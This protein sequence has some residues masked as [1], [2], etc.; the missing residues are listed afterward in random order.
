VPLAPELA[1]YLSL[2]IAEGA[3]AAGGEV[4][5][6]FV[7]IG[8]EGTVALVRPKRENPTG[9]AES[10]IRAILARLLDASGALTPAL[11]AASRK[12]QSTGLASLIE[13]LEAAL[14]P[15]NRAAGRRALA[16]LAREVK[17]VT[18]GVGRNAPARGSSPSYAAVRDAGPDSRAPSR[19]SFSDDPPVTAK[20]DV[21]H[22]VLAGSVP[23]ELGAPDAE[24]A[25]PSSGDASELPTIELRKEQLQAALPKPMRA[26]LPASA[27]RIDPPSE[28][29]RAGPDE[30]DHL[31]ESFGVSSNDEQAAA[32]ELKALVGLDPTPP[33]PGPGHEDE[34]DI[35]GRLI[36]ETP[37]P[38]PP[39]DRPSGTA[40][41][42]DSADVES[43][44]AMSEPGPPVVR[45]LPRAPVALPSPPTAV[46]AQAPERTSTSAPTSPSLRKIAIAAGEF[47]PPRAPRTDR[48]LALIALFILF[49]GAIAIWMLKPGFFT[50]RTPDRIEEERKQAEV[51]RAQAAAAQ[52]AARCKATLI[53]T[54]VPN[55]AEVLLRVGQAPADVE[56]MPV[57]ARLEFVA[58][59]EGFAPKRT[60]VP[61]GAK[62]DTGPDGKP[63][64]EVA[65]Q[66]DKSRAR[67]GGV[68][69]WPAGEPGS[70]V[71][72][73]GS[74]GTV[75]LVSTPR[76][77]ELWL[78]AGIGPEAR[79]DQLRCGTDVD[80]LVAGP[81]TLRK[82]IHVA[83]KDMTGGE[84]PLTVSASGK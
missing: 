15:V 4:D 11:G 2:E 78:L 13:E 38:V 46:M 58:T 65:V 52:Q 12:K 35:D 1:G 60:V 73:K 37:A 8:D 68:D 53:V 39:P 44:L 69:H 80:V 9:D 27:S 71:G 67:P 57:G 21:P 20:R 14:I 70:E 48:V 6:R 41:P 63:R 51:D 64:F 32:R 54:D 40:A 30:V 77:A 47:T 31:L 81:T 22:D 43:L 49:G 42:H 26:P 5:P 36:G 29:P 23:P 79:I 72:G 66:L 83:A 16:R 28:P 24:P 59:A 55:N 74:P 56:R 45:S 34:R 3:D 75:H 18:L 82:R 76:G 7:Y 62:W 10:S 84:T 61:A 25:P 50:G 19:A 17:R 33:P